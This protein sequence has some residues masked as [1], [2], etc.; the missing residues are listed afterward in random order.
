MKIISSNFT[1]THIQKEKKTET[2][3]KY[4][5]KLAIFRCEVVETYFEYIS[6]VAKKVKQ[7]YYL[8]EIVFV[9]S[10]N[11]HSNG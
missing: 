2:S 3:L 1:D 4:N 7:F 10:L 8:A 6:V 5:K 9:T 11:L